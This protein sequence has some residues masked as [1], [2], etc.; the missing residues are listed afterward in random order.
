MHEKSA[1]P[2]ID[3]TALAARTGVWVGKKLPTAAINAEDLEK[4]M[5]GIPT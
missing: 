3:I 4:S 1:T 5:L 2:A